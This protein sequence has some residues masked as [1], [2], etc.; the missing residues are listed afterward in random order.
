MSP[1]QSVS[2]PSS[3]RRSVDEAQCAFADFKD[4]IGP[5]QQSLE[6]AIAE[7]PI[8]AVIFSLATGVFLGWLVKR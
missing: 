6:Q 1:S 8:Q 5:F 3:V 4:V 2:W 7:H